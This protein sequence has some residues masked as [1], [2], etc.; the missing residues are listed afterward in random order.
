MTAAGLR[1]AVI[2]G[3]IGG[4]AVARALALRGASVTL[5]EQA[6]AFGE[7]GAGIQIAP[8]GV[9]VIEALGLGEA[10]AALASVPPAISL[11]DGRSGREVARVPLGATA[12]ARYGRP[13]WQF[14]RADLIGFLADGLEEAGITLRLGCRVASVEAM[15]D[16]VRLAAGEGSQAFDVVIGA[17]GL[18]SPLRMAQFGGSRAR[19]TG[20][21]AWRGLVPAER[22]ARPPSET[23]VF[24]GSRRH[25]VAYPLRAGHLVNLVAIERRRDWVEEGWTR[26]DDPA[27]VRAAFAGWC[28]EVSALLA[29]LEETFL[30]GLFDHAP[31]ARWTRGRLAL[32]G[33]ACHPMLPFLAQGATMALEDAWILAAEL[34]RAK[35]PEA[36]LAAYERRRRE[37]A[38]RVQW[39]AARNGRIY[40]LRYPLTL[41]VHAALGL[42]SRFAPG[43]LLGRFDWIFG[44]DVV[45]ATAGSRSRSRNRGS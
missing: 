14:H 29:G 12:R 39:A 2:G 31:L 33:D 15:A 32:L 10:A 23:V 22:L 35:W 1:V 42:A 40:H 37:R 7:V 25:L 41:P 26:R 20:H 8:N 11:R 16:H 3:G 38:T 19:F 44:E 24:M 4:I 28:D 6:P 17:D 9:A 34:D 43:R 13:Y 5:F 21:V 30:W 45:A 36:G 18:R 27:T